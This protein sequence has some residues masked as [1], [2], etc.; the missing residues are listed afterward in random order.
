MVGRMR[1]GQLFGGERRLGSR[2]LRKGRG[3]RVLVGF[4]VV[5]IVSRA[6]LNLPLGFGDVSIV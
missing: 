3:G 5:L 4:C 6:V 1:T 2:L